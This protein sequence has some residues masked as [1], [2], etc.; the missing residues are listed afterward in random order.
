MVE[1]GREAPSSRPGPSLQVQVR[2]V[3]EDDVALSS[4]TANN[5]EFVL[6]DN[7]RMAGPAPWNRSAN[8]W[9]SPSGCGDIEDDN[10]GEVFTMLI[11][12]SKHDQFITLVQRRS[13]A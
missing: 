3:V 6:V 1:A 5:K 12:A 8:V 4:N 9:L 13:M 2:Q 11:L 7:S 10:V